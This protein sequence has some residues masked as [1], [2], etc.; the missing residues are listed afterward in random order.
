[1]TTEKALVKAEPIVS[2]ALADM[3]E[4]GKVLAES[5]M[6]PGITNKAQAVAK[7]L[8]GRELGLS[9][10]YSLQQIYV[11]QGRLQI[12]YQL[13]A[14]LINR[15]EHYRYQ[16]E[17]L[18]DTEC[19]IMFYRDGKTIGPPSVFTFQDA[20]KAGLVKPESN[21]AKYP[22]IMLFARAI[23]QGARRYCPE[24]LAGT[25]T[26]DES[27][28]ELSPN[29]EM[30]KQGEPPASGWQG[31]WVEAKQILPDENA[32]HQALGVTSI[33][34]WLGQGKSFE[35]AL[36]VLRE[37]KADRDI[38]ELWPKPHAASVA[39]EREIA[40]KP[41]GEP[42]GFNATQIFA[43]PIQLSPDRVDAL[44]RALTAAG[45]LP[46]PKRDKLFRE[47]KIEKLADFTVEQAEKLETWAKAKA[48]GDS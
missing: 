26:L 44:S 19:H 5:G 3:L 40:Q 29:G 9:P 18:T 17:L 27:G 1:M 37:K 48:K 8:L 35:D 14:A 42:L 28:H 13:V 45:Y 25:E 20:Q 46:G 24:L 11:V 16:V 32:I 43:K 7:I 30:S 12:G 22:D 23:T 41:S 21:W 33:H 2:P 4:L 36:K 10:V 15:S 39:E 31:F 38:E 34:D 47:L 6:F